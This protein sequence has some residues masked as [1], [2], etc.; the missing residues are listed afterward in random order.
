MARGKHFKG[1]A[2]GMSGYRSVISSI[3]GWQQ[4][5]DEEIIAEAVAKT[6][7]YADPDW[8]SLFGV[9]SVIGAENVKPLLLR[10]RSTDFDWVADAITGSKAP[11]GDEHVNAMMLASGDPDLIKLAQAT[12]YNKS[13][14]Q[15]FKVPEDPV[16]IQ[17]T[18]NLMRVDILCEAGKSISRSRFN[19]NMQ[20]WDN[21]PGP[22]TPPPQL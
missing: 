17:N 22:P 14:C 6:I 9:A 4:K 18:I 1:E 13:L 21:W 19:E 20:A 8:W 11:F 2:K 10:L 15:Q 12:R 7:P 3:E 16:A 5:T